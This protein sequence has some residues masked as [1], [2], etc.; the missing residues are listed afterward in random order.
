MGE[1]VNHDQEGAFICFNSDM[2][3]VVGRMALTTM[4]TFNDEYRGVDHI[5]V[6]TG[7]NDESFTGPTLFRVALENQPNLFDKILFEMREEGFG[8]IIAD[9]PH[10]S[11]LQTFNDF[12]DKAFN[13][14][15]TNKKIRK[16]LKNE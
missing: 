10:E 7:E 15:V 8:E 5:F 3:M 4:F 11:D 13:P 12:I 2:G 1:F 9:V 14:K 6:I 16:W